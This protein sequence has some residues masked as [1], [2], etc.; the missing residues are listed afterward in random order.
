MGEKFLSL[1]EIIREPDLYYAHSKEDKTQKTQ[2]ETLEEHTKLCQEYF[3]K[4]C[5][6]KQIEKK[7]EHFYRIY[8]G[9]TSKEAK[10]LFD[11]MWKNVVTFHD[12][13]KI[14]PMFQRVALGRTEVAENKEYYL[15]GSKHSSLS[16]VIYM[17]YY[18]KKAEQIENW[19]E[20]QR[21]L[22]L[23]MYNGYIISRHHSGLVS[24]SDFAAGEQK[25]EIC[26]AI[27]VLQKECKK[28]CKN[29]F[30]FDKDCF[31]NMGS[32]FKDL[33]RTKKQNIWLYFYEKLL[34]S[35]LVASDYYATSEYV[36]GVKTKD[37]G[38][39]ED[40][41]DLYEA[42]QKT[43]INQAI[44]EYETTLYPMETEKLQKVED[45]NVLRKEI[46]CVTKRK[47]F[48]MWKHQLAA[49]SLIYP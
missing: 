29:E 24:A 39:L 25:E 11:A 16:S 27:K 5:E 3:G 38:E 10:E 45:I 12:M 30:D 8:M 28:V 49:V 48:F 7:M 14:N 42:F 13:G 20:A 2:Y 46:C 19:E 36:S 22:L 4:I 32:N 21:L 17:E 23:I 35:L 18:L 40:I 1:K 34:Y 37:L 26:K 47:P 33:P 9:E 15:V 41:T 44:R 43:E 6:N 31:E